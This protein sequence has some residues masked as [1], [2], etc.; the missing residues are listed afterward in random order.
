MRIGGQE[1]R[2]PESI[3]DYYIDY[4][5]TSVHIS[6]DH[7]GSM[8]PRNPVRL[9]FDRLKVSGPSDLRVTESDKVFV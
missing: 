6:I 1:R 8:N 2:W 4:I 3:R 9:I 7:I 5:E